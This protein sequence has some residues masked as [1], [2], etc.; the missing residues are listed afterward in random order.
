MKLKRDE[1]KKVVCVSPEDHKYIEELYGK[2][3][4]QYKVQAV[5][6]GVRP[7]IGKK[8]NGPRHVIN[9]LREHSAFGDIEIRNFAARFVK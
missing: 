9:F 3:T 7:T 2:I 6:A 8:G 1:E 4:E 5:L